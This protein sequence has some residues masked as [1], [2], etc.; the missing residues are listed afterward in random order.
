[1]G[2]VY[3]FAGPAGSGKTIGVLS[4]CPHFQY[5]APVESNESFLS[6]YGRQIPVKTP[7]I[8]TTIAEAFA[9]YKAI[10][11]KAKASN[12][13]L[14]GIIVDEWSI[15]SQNHVLTLQEANN[16]WESL[17]IY[18]NTALQFIEYM[19]SCSWP[20]IIIG[21]Y[22]QPQE[23]HNED[24][25]VIFIPGTM[26]SPGYVLPSALPSRVS[27]LFLV[28]A[29]DKHESG[30]MITRESTAG[31]VIKD[32]YNISPRTGNVPNNIR[33]LSRRLDP[34]SFPYPAELAW[35]DDYITRGVAMLKEG[36]SSIADIEQEMIKQLPGK[37]EKQ[38]DFARRQLMDYV[39]IHRAFVADKAA[40]KQLISSIITLE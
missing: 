35:V 8:V 17:K 40:S 30:H 11:E 27:A 23:K 9:K 22:M 28:V 34:A 3:A 4:S 2:R 10:A 6:L 15:L 29:D 38:Y 37:H 31:A 33:L 26:Q 1:M 25:R 20:T 39:L 24:G 32:R 13:Q 12:V 21:H 7:H 16:V 19:L 14:P 5:I 18:N 36:K